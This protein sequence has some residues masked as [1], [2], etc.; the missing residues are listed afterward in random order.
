MQLILGDN[1]SVETL[2]EDFLWLFWRVIVVWTSLIMEGLE[3]SIGKNIG[4]GVCVFEELLI[5]MARRCSSSRKSTKRTLPARRWSAMR[6]ARCALWG[7][8]FD[9]RIGKSCIWIG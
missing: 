8:G 7:L 4:V 3:H 1:G 9:F 2:E 5:V 6:W